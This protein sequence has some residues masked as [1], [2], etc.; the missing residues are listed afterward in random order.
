ME[1]GKVDVADGRADN[2]QEAR[3]V[4][5]GLHRSKEWN[6][7]LKF[8]VREREARRREKED[9]KL[10]THPIFLKSDIGNQRVQCRTDILDCRKEN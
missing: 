10:E 8:R 1:E 2:T 3:N 9:S 5:V 7:S 4:R 6:E